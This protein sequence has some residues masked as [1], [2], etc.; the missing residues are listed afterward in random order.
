MITDDLGYAAQYLAVHPLFQ[1]GA[2]YLRNFD[3]GT[4]KGRYEL[5]G[6]RLF[7]LVQHY[8]TRLPAEKQFES[9]KLYADVQYVAKGTE[10]IWYAPRS[11][12]QPKTEYEAAKDVQFYSDPN[13]GQQ[14]VRLKAGEFA[15]FFP[16]DG[17]KPG[18]IDETED[19]VIKVVLKLHL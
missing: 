16:Q 2:D 12:L 8:R 1:K 9:H 6:D 3:P 7:A 15:V 18:C 19:E 5:E 17:H 10:C 4:P 14:G 13:R 11:L